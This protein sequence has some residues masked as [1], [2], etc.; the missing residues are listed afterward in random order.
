MLHNKLNSRLCTNL[1]L[2]GSIRGCKQNV[3]AMAWVA[4]LGG[5]MTVITRIPAGPPTD[6]PMVTASHQV[7][8][9]HGHAYVI[10]TAMQPQNQSSKLSSPWSAGCQFSA[11]MLMLMVVML[12]LSLLPTAQ[13]SAW[14]MLEK[15]PAPLLSKTTMAAS[16]NPGATAVDTATRT[17]Q[18]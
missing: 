3:T 17:A 2:I 6:V 10:C 7:D 14:R 11:A 4:L 5:V 18:Q 9:V 15:L 8:Q 12:Y 1:R 16:C 13:L